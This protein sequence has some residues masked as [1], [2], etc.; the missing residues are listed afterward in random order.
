MWVMVGWAIRVSLGF[1]KQW[2]GNEEDRRRN[3]GWGYTYMSLCLNWLGFWV[4]NTPDLLMLTRGE[5]W[6]ALKWHLWESKVTDLRGFSQFWGTSVAVKES[7]GG[8]FE[9]IKIKIVGE[10]IGNLETRR[11]NMS[12]AP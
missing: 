1:K 10:E 7:G 3:F 5:L 6:L 8:Y 11:E 12:F 2:C 4:F 9:K